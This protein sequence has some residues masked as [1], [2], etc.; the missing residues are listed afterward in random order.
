MKIL[1]NI[2]IDESKSFY[3][4]GSSEH[5]F[6]ILRI[7][8]KQEQHHWE[9]LRIDVRR[10]CCEC[11]RPWLNSYQNWI[12]KQLKLEYFRRTEYYPNWWS[13]KEN[14]SFPYATSFN[15][16]QIQVVNCDNWRRELCFKTSLKFKENSRFWRTDRWLCAQITTRLTHKQANELRYSTKFKKFFLFEWWNTFEQAVR[17]D[18]WGE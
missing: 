15:P 3:G 1:L 5:S 7:E 14:K 4:K 10:W 11:P 2:Y 9:H 16:V 17:R 18:W 12:A 13:S 6:S 8:T